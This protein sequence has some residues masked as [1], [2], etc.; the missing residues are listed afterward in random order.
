VFIPKLNTI[1]K[2]IGEY[3]YNNKLPHCLSAEV[4]LFSVI[5]ND[6]PIAWLTLVESYHPQDSDPPIY[7][8]ANLHFGTYKE[9]E[10]KFVKVTKG[11]QRDKL[12]L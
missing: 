8:N 11:I 2:V 6:Y 1:E 4:I 7:R 5:D 10:E 3:Y 9:F 12:K